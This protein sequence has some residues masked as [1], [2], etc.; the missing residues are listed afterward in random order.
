MQCTTNIKCIIFLKRGWLVFSVLGMYLF[1]GKFCAKSDGSGE[2]SCSQ[3]MQSR[4][5]HQEQVRLH[6]R[7]ASAFRPQVDA[8]SGE[9]ACICDRKNFNTFLWATVTVFMVS[10]AQKKSFRLATSGRYIFGTN[11]RM[12]SPDFWMPPLSFLLHAFVVYI[13]FL[14]KFEKS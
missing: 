7:L 4:R 11:K 10:T 14:K 12:F 2:C 3:M 13:P 5:L 9:V 8:A 1:G 6:G